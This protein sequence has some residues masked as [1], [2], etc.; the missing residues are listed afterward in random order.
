MA[1]TIPLQKLVNDFTAANQS[2]LDDEEFMRRLQMHHCKI[3]RWVLDK[4]ADWVAHRILELRAE[5]LDQLDHLFGVTTPRK[6][7]TWSDKDRSTEIERDRAR[8]ETIE[9][10]RGAAWGSW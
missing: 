4:E 7:L 9:K 2:D 5:E 8:K 3:S 10:S 1:D 6:H